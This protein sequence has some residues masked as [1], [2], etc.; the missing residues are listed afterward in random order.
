MFLTSN[1]KLTLEIKKESTNHLIT[2]GLHDGYLLFN[3]MLH[4][5]RKEKSIIFFFKPHLKANNKKLIKLIKSYN[6]SNL[7]IA[8]KHITEYLSFVDKVYFG[9]T[10]V[11]QEAEILGIDTKVI[12]SKIKINESIYCKK[13]LFI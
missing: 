1:N 13:E 3:E 9:Y 8:N 11:G 6:L 5:I 4:T 10:S 7:F 2:C 12:F